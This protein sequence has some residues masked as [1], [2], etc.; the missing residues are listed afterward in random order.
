MTDSA[1]LELERLTRHPV[2]L[3]GFQAKSSQIAAGAKAEVIITNDKNRRPAV[4]ETYSKAV[5]RREFMTY[6]ATGLLSLLLCGTSYGWLTSSISAKNLS[7]TITETDFEVDSLMETLRGM[8]LIANSCDEAILEYSS[9]YPQRLNDIVQLKSS[10]EQIQ[11]LYA[12]L[13]ETGIN[14]ADAIQFVFDLLSLIPN[15]E[16]YTQ[17]I[18]TMMEV[19]MKTPETLRL[20]HGATSNLE[21]WFCNE[22]NQGLHNRLFAPAHQ[23]IQELKDNIQPKVSAIRARLAGI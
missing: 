4:V 11:N 15:A 20:A 22:Q 3:A 14:V 5:T 16:K 18:S 23:I 13:D 7:S 19:V 8:Q 12:Q 10:L 9:I 1:L 2:D 21:H 6:S 17:P